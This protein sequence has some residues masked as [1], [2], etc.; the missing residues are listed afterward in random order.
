MAGEDDNRSDANVL[1]HSEGNFQRSYPVPR[2]LFAGE[3]RAILNE[4]RRVVMLVGAGALGAR[5]EVIR[6]A[7]LIGA[8]VVKALLGKAVIPDRHPLATEASACWARRPLRKR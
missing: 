5:E 1:S 4:G 7:E 3:G 6:L 8:P 2:P